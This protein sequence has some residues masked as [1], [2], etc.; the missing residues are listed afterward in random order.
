MGPAPD[1]DIFV[2][3]AHA[4]N[5]VPVGSSVQLGWV[6]AL[7][8]N[9][10]EGP[11]V[12]KKRIFIDHRLRPGD[13]FSTDLLTTLGQTSILLL[14][15]SQNYVDSEWCGK[16]V[17]HFARLNGLDDA[18]KAAIFV[19]ELVPFERLSGVPSTILSLRKRFINAKFWYQGLEM[20]EPSLAG[21]PS[22]AESGPEARTHYWKVLNE[23]RA[24]L[25]LRLRGLRGA[26]GAR[27]PETAAPIAEAKAEGRPADLGTVLLA[28]ATED[29]EA[30]HAAVRM[31]LEPEGIRV[32]PAGDYV[33][34]NP[35]E[36]REAFAEDLDRADLFVQLLS[37]AAGRKGRH[38]A[39][40]PQLQHRWA[41][42]AGKPVLQWS[43][44]L[45]GAGEVADP[46][47]AALFETT[48]LRVTHLDD[49]K[50]EVIEKLRSLKAPRV[51]APISARGLSDRQIFLDT[52]SSD[53]SLTERL[54]AILRTHS[55]ELRSV[56]ADLP[57]GYGGID[58]KD[59]LRPC[60]A[61]LTIYTDK[62]KQ[63]MACQRLWYLLRQVTEARLP[64][65]RWGVYLCD[66]TVASEFGIESDQVVQVD[67]KN[68]GD[69]LRGL[70]P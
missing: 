46:A 65:A 28:D 50:T 6:S 1:Y 25:D 21:Y 53:E 20:S 59:L 33:E 19:V 40:K 69:F 11:N 67:E 68:L 16:E 61:G 7:A 51:Q 44:S 8:A 64:V 55:Y 58:V 27:V 35:S 56:P 15:L 10:N 13:A 29:L 49:F 4:D 32:V 60:R 36:F 34:L 45:P 31:A 18:C 66:G 30:Q 54:R 38:D 47:H 57:L 23:L 14:L 22:P 9:L 63:V 17:E 52:V 39:P 24:A 5:G 3:Y 43:R 12:L 62:S 26:S 37:P 70:D 42:A 2:S 48:T 41:T